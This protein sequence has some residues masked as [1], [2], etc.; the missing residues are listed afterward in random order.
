MPITMPLGSTTGRPLILWCSISRNASSTEAPGATLT[1]SRVITSLAFMVITPSCPWSTPRSDRHS[2]ATWGIKANS[3]I[4]QAQQHIWPLP[5]QLRCNGF[6]S[7]RSQFETDQQLNHERMLIR[8]AAQAGWNRR[9]AALPASSINERI[10]RRVQRWSRSKGE[11]CLTLLDRLQIGDYGA[12][13]V[14]VECELGHVWMARDNSLAQSLFKKLDW[15]VRRKVTKQRSLRVPALAGAADGM[16]ASAVPCE[17]SLATPDVAR[18][19]GACG[20]YEGG[21]K[22]AMQYWSHHVFLAQADFRDGRSARFERIIHRR[23]RMMIWI[24]LTTR[25]SGKD[26][27]AVPHFAGRTTASLLTT[28]KTGDLTSLFRR[29]HG[30]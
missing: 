27:M 15:I 18:V 24:K 22:G 12:D 6:T 16:A 17:E 29:L 19:V 30:A 1:T 28:R 9:Y 7:G 25:R 20:G 4:A 14:T 26:E 21:N 3:D 23:E 13:I 2:P 8:R 10:R 5:F 11:S